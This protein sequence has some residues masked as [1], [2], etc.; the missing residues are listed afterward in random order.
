M[1]ELV[2]IK[3]KETCEGM[4]RE[5]RCPHCQSDNF[6]DDDQQGDIVT[7]NDCEEKS[8][9]APD[10]DGERKLYV[11]TG[12]NKNYSSGL[13]IAIATSLTKARHLVIENSEWDENDIHH[14]GNLTIKNL[15][16]DYAVSV[17]GG[18]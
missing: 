6:I 7:C 9:T 3:V 16:E 11:W 14:W 8:S 15:D 12:F 13:G 17:D 10:V 2:H 4:F 1:S 18:G 5:W